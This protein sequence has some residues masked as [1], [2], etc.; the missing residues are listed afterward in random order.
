MA[1]KDLHIGDTVR[2]LNATGGGVIRTLSPDG[3]VG[4][5]D[6]S[7]FVLP[8]LESEVVVV[9]E[10]STIVPSIPR[11][12]A[13]HREEKATRKV[14][15][16]STVG[17]TSPK[18][19]SRK[20]VQREGADKL[21]VYMA[22]LPEYPDRVGQCDYEVYLINDSDYDLRVLYMSGEGAE[23]VLSYDEI[24][25]YDSQVLVETFAPS[26]LPRRAR[27]RVQIIPMKVDE[28]FVPK[29]SVDLDIKIEGARFFKANAFAPNDFFDDGAILFELIRDDRPVHIKRLD[30]KGLEQEMMHKKEQDSHPNPSRPKTQTPRKSDIKV[31]DL[32][33]HELVDTTAGMSNHDMLELQLDVARKALKEEADHKS[34]KVVLVHGKGE[35]VLRRAVLDMIR[36]EFPRFEVSDAS[37]QEYGFGASQVTIH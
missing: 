34:A 11:P 32:H 2:F 3:V 6:E 33:I 23:R 17:S 20:R 16:S 22:Y 4:V 27:T 14:H 13:T 12:T 37:F 7:G 19:T 24:V 1:H 25:P 31:V 18:S 35:G 28:P 30:T 9:T 36:R 10:G 21:N 5:E 29:P 8:V 26:A 15:E